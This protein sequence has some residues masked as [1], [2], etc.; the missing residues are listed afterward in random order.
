[1][2]PKQDRE[3]PKQKELDTDR[4]NGVEVTG[5]TAPA[6]PQALPYRPG[7]LPNSVDVIG[8]VPDSIHV[9]PDVTEGH[10]GYDESGDSEIIPLERLAAAEPREKK[11]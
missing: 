2:A 8:M 6:A 4:D 3:M 11:E 7:I 5:G 1:M 9:D 10:P